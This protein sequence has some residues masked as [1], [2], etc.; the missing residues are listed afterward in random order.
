MDESGSDATRHDHL[1][2]SSGRH[3]GEVQPVELF[4]DLVY[5]LA[6]TQ[7][8]HHLLGSLSPRGALETL[9][10]LWG[11]WAG[12]ICVT[13]ISNY[14]DVRM[15]AVRLTLLI[16]A[17]VGL[18]LASSIPE[19]FEERGMTVAL[20]VVLLIAG[21]PLLGMLAVGASHPLWP[22]LRRVVIWDALAGGLWV[23]GA[24]ANGNWRL[25]LWLLASLLIGFVIYLGFPL[26]RLGHNR[27]TDYPITGTH[28]AERCLLFVILA[29][30]ES[31]LIT[32]EG[33][34]ELPH[35][36]AV[37]AAFIVAFT[38][39]VALWWIYFD[40]TIEL[41]R[42]R[43]DSAADPGRFGV[44]AYTFYHM[45]IVAGII[46]TAAGDELSVAHPTESASQAAR[47]VLLG[48][49]A[50][51]LLGNLLFKAVMFDRISRVQGVAIVV[52]LALIPMLRSGTHLQTALAAVVV[53]LAII[54]W[55]L[56]RDR[57]EFVSDRHLI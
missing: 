37:W 46:V 33:F 11:V 6:V 53:L 28:M 49:P 23:A 21:A 14:F 8:T 32:G 51:F 16:G 55:D 35:T 2:R 19:A 31:I 17:F 56:R 39:S 7:L 50:L 13:W 5:A 12:W 57:H 42:A 41:A 36:R 54:I 47:L 24:L 3:A 18:V 10:L 4:F 27:T 25:T 45:Y 9:A 30:G 26:P 38:G 43:M 1:L 20:A 40:R 52:L 22:V 29:L 48:G 34:G 44:L 15:R